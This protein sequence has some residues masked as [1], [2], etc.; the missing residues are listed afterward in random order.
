MDRLIEPIIEGNNCSSLMFK[1]Y[2]ATDIMTPNRDRIIICKVNQ[3]QMR[4][5]QQI[6]SGE[7][8]LLLLSRWSNLDLTV[9]PTYDWIL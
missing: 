7:F 2:Y 1:M 3:Y 4:L 5:S 8:M 6:P 9:R